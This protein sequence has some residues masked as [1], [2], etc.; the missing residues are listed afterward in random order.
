MTE[1]IRFAPVAVAV[2]FVKTGNA[3]KGL[4]VSLISNT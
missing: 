2:I 1:N 3:C 4:I